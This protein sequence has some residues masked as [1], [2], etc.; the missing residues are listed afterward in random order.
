MGCTS[1]G[2][3]FIKIVSLIC[4]FPKYWAEVSLRLCLTTNPCNGA[5][6]CKSQG[7]N[8]CFNRW[9]LRKV[10]EPIKDMHLI[11][12]CRRTEN[13]DFLQYR[14]LL[15]RQISGWL[16]PYSIEHG[17]NNFNLKKYFKHMLQNTHLVQKIII[18]PHLTLSDITS[19]KTYMKNELQNV[20]S[21]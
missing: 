21:R 20:L 7:L 8:H 15:F 4:I 5:L 10:E 3:F 14:S 17:H 16:K 11:S 6:L 9:P 1:S 18:N 13:L 19:C 2:Q 12:K